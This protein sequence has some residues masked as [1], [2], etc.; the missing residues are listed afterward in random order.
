MPT[1]FENR[2]GPI[3]EDRYT[4]WNLGEL[5]E[6]SFTEESN[7][8][9]RITYDLNLVELIIY[10][11]DSILYLGDIVQ[12]NA[13]L[14]LGDGTYRDVTNIVEWSLNGSPDIAYFDESTPGLLWTQVTGTDIVVANFGNIFTTYCSLVVHNPLIIPQG[15]DLLGT[16]QPTTEIYVKLITSQYQTSPKFLN[17]VKG[18]LDI[19]EDIRELAQSL[20]YY[21]SFKLLVDPQTSYTDDALT[22]KQ[23]E[24]PFDFYTFECAVGKQL[25]RL[26]ELIGQERRVYFKE[27]PLTS[28]PTEA[29]WVTLSDTDYRILLKNKMVVNTWDGK[30]QSLQR[31]WGDLFPGGK[32]IIQDNQ[33]MS[34]N[35]TIT[36]KLSN[37][38]INLIL[39]EYIVPRPQ[40]VQY[41][42]YYGLLPFFGF[43]RDDD[44]VA[45]FDKGHFV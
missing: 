19:T 32:I 38:V 3:F 26:G 27:N 16:Y 20:I 9:D 18:F 39:N 15:R 12:Y 7:S 2:E 1:F 10:P 6:K 21:F 11:D 42:Y 14:R 24:A 29:Q 13:I 43:D 5:F 36:G 23:G 41:N 35:V 22:I 34:V 30:A 25:D 33:D 44:Y 37:T 4:V 45:G 28:P 17:W 40:G 31:A 8:V